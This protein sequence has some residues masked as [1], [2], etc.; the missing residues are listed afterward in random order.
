MSDHLNDRVM[1][2]SSDSDGILAIFAGAWILLSWRFRVLGCVRS[3]CVGCCA[4]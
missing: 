2:S 1:Q 4:R 3:D